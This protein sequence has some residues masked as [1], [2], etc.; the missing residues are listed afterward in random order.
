MEIGEKNSKFTFKSNAHDHQ[1]DTTRFEGVT[2]NL[3]VNY[4][5][6]AVTLTYDPTFAEL[7]ANR[8]DC[9]ESSKRALA[10]VL[11]LST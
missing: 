4:P 9:W 1:V 11:G 8:M 5:A 3:N 7:L 6:S 10:L 2:C